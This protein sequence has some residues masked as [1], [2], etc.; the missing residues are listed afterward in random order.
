MQGEFIGVIEYDMESIRKLRTEEPESSSSSDSSKGSHHPSQEC[1]MAETS[2][3]HVESVFEGEAT[4]TRNP[5]ARTEGEAA[6]PPHVRM[7][8]LR[9]RKLEIDD[10]GQQLVREY[11]KINEEIK[12]RGDGGHARATA[13][14]IHQRILTNDRTL[15]HITLASQNITAATALLHGLPEATT[16]E[17]RRAHREIRTL[18]ERAA[19]QQVESSLSQRRELDTSQ[20]TPSMHPAR[21][22]SVHQAPQGAG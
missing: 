10:A 13:R 6:A 15:P 7:E 20:R 9:A 3:G 4:L 14:N 1:F 12:R 11:R 2:E 19:A 18:L 8:Q 21:D 5:N 16:S 22:V 17:D